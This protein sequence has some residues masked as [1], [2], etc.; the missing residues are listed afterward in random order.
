MI[1]S[2]SL[3]EDDVNYLLSLQE[4]TDAKERV[5]LL[6]NSGHINFSISIPLD[7]KEKIGNQIGINLSG[8]DTI[9]MR[10]IKGDTPAHSDRCVKSFDK[11]YL[12]YLTDSEG[13]LVVDGD[14]YAI[15]K[16]NAYVFS[17]GLM[18]ETTGTGTLPRLLLGP[19]SE[20]G[21]YV[22]A[23]SSISEPGGT[24]IYVRQN[25]GTGNYEYSTDNQASWN[26]FN[27]PVY[28]TNTN[29]SLGYLNVEF[30]NDITINSGSA[31][32]T[33]ASTYIRFGSTTLPVGGAR[34]KIYVIGVSGYPGLIQNGTSFSGG[35]GNVN[36][37][38]IITD[39]SG[40]TLAADAGWL[41][42]NYFGREAGSSSYIINCS[43][44]GSIDQ[45]NTGGI[46][47][48]YAYYASPQALYIYGC[49]STGQISGSSAGGIVGA[50]AAS[51]DSSGNSSFV[52][53]SYCW[54][55]NQISGVNAGGIFGG[56]AG[57]YNVPAGVAG[58]GGA[59]AQNSYSIG[60]ITGDNAGGIF[61]QYAGNSTSQTT[62]VN[63]CYSHGSITGT[64]SGGIFGANAGNVGPVQVYNCYSLG[65][66]G[67]SAGGGIYGV[68]SS[69]SEFNT[70]TAYGFWNDASA[71]SY[72]LGVP[73]T[74]STTAVGNTWARSS[75]SS[76][77][78][79]P[80]ELYP[81]GFSPYNLTNITSDSS[82]SFIFF[83]LRQSYTT[84]VVA[85]SST[86]GS[87]L[88]SP[89][90]PSDYSLLQISGGTPSS[91]G[92]FLISSANGSIVT[93]TSTAPGLYTLYIRN[94]GSYN[95]TTFNL[96]VTEEPT[97]PTPPTPLSEICFPAG[98]PVQ[99]DQGIVAIDKINTDVHTIKNRKIEGVVTTKLKDDYL[100]CFERNAIA[101]NI[102]CEKT[103]MSGNHKVYYNGQMRKAK[104]LLNNVNCIYK[105]RYNRET[106]YN[107]LMEKHETMLV[108]NMVCETLDPTN[109]M[110]K[111]F[112]CLK[113]MSPE[114]QKMLV[115]KMNQ[116]VL[117]NMYSRIH[118]KKS[119]KM[120]MKNNY[121][122]IKK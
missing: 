120:D 79:T 46:V 60:N 86:P 69:V 117:N 59:G 80:Y 10:W 34:R 95:I 35:Y 119:K 110:A 71:N 14:A 33:C 104:E 85:G 44:N 106:M 51:T 23:G 113:D 17:E 112:Y 107:V 19:M 16:G 56:R 92:T 4:V 90:L 77:S 105:V 91:Y 94:T 122:Y 28:L 8:M 61:G 47:G 3:Y 99:T 13:S 26:I 115:D 9:P 29:T 36:I 97:P 101:L 54:S 89:T 87:V 102:P 93:S 65:I 84:S 7:L 11:T 52:V 53:C 109:N 111:I 18:H 82:G 96:N 98:T 1:E 6:S 15:A 70:Y 100:V 2:C 55:E 75:L 108:N 78:D 114:K 49:S 32:F 22:G 116:E 57:G 24:T 63:Q 37:F 30:V 81:M 68:S 21:I 121:Q 64:G 31:F 12:A 67:G 27:F 41:A 74:G 45:S 88:T 72:L 39:S 40:S 48:A 25:F 118:S 66:V 62:Y 73:S 42:Q 58:L 83:N 38:N 50:F 76:I 103:Y 5:D 20:E 43:S